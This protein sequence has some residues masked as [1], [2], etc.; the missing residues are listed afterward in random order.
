MPESLV[1]NHKNGIKTDNSF[2]N[3]EAVPQR[4][5]CLHAARMGLMSKKKTILTDEQRKEIIDLYPRGEYPISQLAKMYGVERRTIS[6]LLHKA[7][8]PIFP[9][10]Y[11]N[12]KNSDKPE[13]FEE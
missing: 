4:E 2:E 12:S 8:L 5:N 13:S 6:N 11:W 7:G 1:I 10:S 9:P 3:L